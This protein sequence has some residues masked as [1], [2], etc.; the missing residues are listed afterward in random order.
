MG[1]GLQFICENKFET[2]LLE[3][4][5]LWFKWSQQMRWVNP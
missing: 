3:P 4:D 1:L 2:N 5:K